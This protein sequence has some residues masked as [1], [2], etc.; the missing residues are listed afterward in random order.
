MNRYQ[1]FGEWS[2]AV[3]VG[4]DIAHALTGRTLTGGGRFDAKANA[5]VGERHLAIVEVKGSRD[6]PKSRRGAHI[7]RTAIVIDDRGLG[8]EVDYRDLGP[9]YDVV[10]PL[11]NRADIEAQIAFEQQYGATAPRT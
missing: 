7:F 8:H 10:P 4:P 11:P 3:Y 2:N 5:V 9:A 6:N 1:L